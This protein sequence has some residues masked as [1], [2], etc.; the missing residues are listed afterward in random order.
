MLTIIKVVGFQA[1]FGIWAGMFPSE[2][3]VRAITEEEAIKG[4]LDQCRGRVDLELVLNNG[5]VVSKYVFEMMPKEA[6]EGYS[7]LTIKEVDNDQDSVFLNYAVPYG[8]K[9]IANGVEI[10]FGENPEGFSFNSVMDVCD[11]EGNN[12]PSPYTLPQNRLW[13]RD[14]QWH[15]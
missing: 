5:L 13:W 1:S 3:P 7:I 6:P 15:H 14:G 10:V 11:D 12:S 8:E 4:L 2:S 9:F